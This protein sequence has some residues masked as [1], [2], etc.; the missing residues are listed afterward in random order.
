MARFSDSPNPGCLG[1]FPPWEPLRLEPLSHEPTYLL[2]TDVNYITK[3]AAS[4][5]CFTSW[6]K[7]T[8]HFTC[9]KM[10]KVSFKILQWCA[11]CQVYSFSSFGSVN[12][13][14]LPV[15]LPWPPS[16]HAS[17]FCIS[18]NSPLRCARDTDFKMK[19]NTWP[20]ACGI[21]IP[22]YL[23][24]VILSRHQWDA[25]PPSVGLQSPRGLAFSQVK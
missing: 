3:G 9:L 25:T 20:Y 23:W 4:W 19:I 24:W 2:Q 8:S 15:F 16:P 22:L 21:R 14:V 12:S 13:R 10:R 1:A 6:S 7:L 5:R 18:E 11:H 17:V